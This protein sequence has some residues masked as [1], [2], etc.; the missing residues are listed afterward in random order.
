[1]KDF[2]ALTVQNSKKHRRWALAAILAPSFYALEWGLVGATA[3]LVTFLKFRGLSDVAIWLV[4]WGLNLLFSGAVV[5]CNDRTKIDFTLMETSRRWTNAAAKKS[6]WV[7]Y[8]IE[9]IVFIRLLLWD[10][11][12]LL[13]IYF[14]ERLP[15]RSLRSAIF[16]AASGFQMFI[17]AQLYILGFESI[18]DLLKALR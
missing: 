15:S 18:G 9:V 6:K 12:C 1:M 2:S 5:L 13:V 7:G 14:K 11:P 8:I 4:L 16:V 17:W 3:G 10:G